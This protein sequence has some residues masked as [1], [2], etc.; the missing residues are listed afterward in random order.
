MFPRELLLLLL[1]LYTSL[2]TK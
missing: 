2:F 1:L